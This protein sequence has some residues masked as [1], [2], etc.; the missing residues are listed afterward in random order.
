MELIHALKNIGY[1]FSVEGDE[2]RY[3]LMPG[4]ELDPDTGGPLLKELRITGK[5]PHPI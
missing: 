4:R 5:R 1:K 2:L 3:Y